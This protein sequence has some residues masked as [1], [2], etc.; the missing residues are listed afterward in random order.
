MLLCI[1][2]F[3]GDERMNNMG[4]MG[5]FGRLASFLMKVQRFMQGRYGQ[6][7]LLNKWICSAAFLSWIGSI[8]ITGYLYIPSFLL[9][10]WGTFRVLSKNIP[11]RYRENQWFL[12]RT[13]GLRTA[14]RKYKANAIQNQGYCIYK[15]PECR[16]KI[17]VPKGKG[18][19]EIHC[20]TC[21]ARFIKRT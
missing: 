12:Q 8:F 11:A 13:Y 19:I 6:S 14:I 21:D 18:R 2:G 7:D 15:C 10:T 5:S 1:P 4:N 3:L 16:Q 20:R 9:W 17:R